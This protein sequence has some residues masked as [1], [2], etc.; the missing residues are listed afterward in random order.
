MLTHI[1]M[2]KVKEH[3]HGMDKPAIIAKI[4]HE[5][6]ALPL[7]IHEIK[8]FEVGIDML[9]SQASY[10]VVLNSTFESKESLDLYQ[11]HPVHEKVKEFVGSVVETRAVIDY[12]K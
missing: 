9:H 2:W 10:D 12:E 7:Q 4:K 3:A 5:L 1:V 6:E 11:I 8:S